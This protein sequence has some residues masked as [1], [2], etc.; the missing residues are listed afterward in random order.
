[1][2][3]APGNLSPRHIELAVRNLQ[4]IGGPIDWFMEDNFLRIVARPN[5]HVPLTIHSKVARAR[6]P[7]NLEDVGCL[8]WRGFDNGLN[9]VERPSYVKPGF[10]RRV[11][12]RMGVESSQEELSV[13]IP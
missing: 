7:E 4:G 10:S 8:T 1:M 6:S 12:R 2:V 13:F 11:C 9:F 5:H 3:A